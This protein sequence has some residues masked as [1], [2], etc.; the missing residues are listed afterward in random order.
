MPS[1]HHKT[2]TNNSPGRVQSLLRTIL[3]E[4]GRETSGTKK[5]LVITSG[6]NHC[7]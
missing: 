7:H 4:Q 6:Q 1:I 2:N 3:E 5:V